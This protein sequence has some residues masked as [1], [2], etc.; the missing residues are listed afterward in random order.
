MR[1]ELSSP[2]SD[3]DPATTG[4][5]ALEYGQKRGMLTRRSVEESRKLCGAVTSSI[6]TTFHE[7]PERSFSSFSETRDHPSKPHFSSREKSVRFE[8]PWRTGTG[9]GIV[10]VIV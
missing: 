6:R 1:K 3:V 4:A 2:A 8:F 5:Q 10:I 9:T 7:T